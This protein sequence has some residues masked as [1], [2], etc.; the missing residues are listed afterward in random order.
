MD[1]ARCR[2]PGVTELIPTLPEG[3]LVYA[4]GD[5][6][7]RADL[8]EALLR[9]IE[10][11]AQAAEARTRTL[12]FL[13][14]YVDRGP[15]SR[16]VIETLVSGL[17]QGFEAHFLKGNH[18]VLLLDF[19]DDPSR[20]DGW[21]LND[22]ETTMASYG[23]DIGA[24]YRA[25][26]RPAEWRDAFAASLPDAHL[27][28]FRNLVLSVTRGDYLFVHAGVRPGV[29]LAAQTE[30]E[31]VWIRRPFLDWAE[32]FEKF[33]VHGHTPGREPVTRTNR[34]GVDTGACFTGRLTALRLVG[35]TRKFLQ[36]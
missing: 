31:L 23:V 8:L 10:G 15:D 25:R 22:A 4:V 27:Q 14:D 21:L 1:A 18:E 6:H 7:G 30:D 17:P 3:E 9:L 32:P 24:L 20:L 36:T 2:E 35:D 19:L 11:D 29:P 16:G 28:F 13:G 5:I 26:A 33:V 34:I 12:I